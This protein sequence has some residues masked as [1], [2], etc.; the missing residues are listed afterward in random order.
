MPI[1]KSPRRVADVLDSE[2]KITGHEIEYAITA[3]GPEAGYVRPQN[4]WEPASAETVDALR[5]TSTAALTA[6]IKRLGQQIADER[7]AAEAAREAAHAA[8]EAEA[9]EKDAAI[10][11]L[12]ALIDE[13][14]AS[15]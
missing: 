15:A 6:E 9:A 2:G 10:A 8:H 12:R 13:A 7:A 4:K 11:A 1:Y 5:A 3:D 14:L